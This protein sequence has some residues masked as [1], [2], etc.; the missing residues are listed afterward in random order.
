[1]PHFVSPQM[2]RSMMLI[3]NEDDFKDFG[4]WETSFRK[5]E[6]S[7]AN[8]LFCELAEATSSPFC[9]DAPNNAETTGRRRLSVQSN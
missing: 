6:H 3:Q 4:I 9:P 5:T 2:I 8:Q 1:M 7:D